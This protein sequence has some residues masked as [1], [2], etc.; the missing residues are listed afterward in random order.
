MQHATVLETVL[1]YC[2]FD[3][4]RMQSERFDGDTMLVPNRVTEEPLPV[5]GPRDVLIKMLAAPMNPADFN[6]VHHTCACLES[7]QAGEE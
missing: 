2:K 3:F 7:L 1:V 6:M 4:E 5:L